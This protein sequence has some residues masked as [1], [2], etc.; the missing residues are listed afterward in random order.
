MSKILLQVQG[1]LKE[2]PLKLSLQKLAG[3]Q[4]TILSRNNFRPL[5]VP[6]PHDIESVKQRAIYL[7][8]LT[9][10]NFDELRNLDV[11][12]FQ[13]LTKGCRDIFR[14]DNIS[15]IVSSLRHDSVFAEAN[16]HQVLKTFIVGLSEIS[17]PMEKDI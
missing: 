2:S 4:E 14:T 3:H 9:R 5:G 15:S 7:Y 12:F 13:L 6:N 17:N 1:M 11:E 16:T 8:T 10:D